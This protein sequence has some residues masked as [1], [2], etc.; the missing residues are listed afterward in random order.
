MEGTAEHFYENC[1][2]S[3]VYLQVFLAIFVEKMVKLCFVWSLAGRR[4]ANYD[5]SVIYKFLVYEL[6]SIY[7]ATLDCVL[8]ALKLFFISEYGHYV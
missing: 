8:P 6:L 2:R 1:E 4:L 7:Y 5:L 3:N